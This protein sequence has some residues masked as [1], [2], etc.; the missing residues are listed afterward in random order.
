MKHL[1][2][3]HPW[4]QLGHDIG[5]IPR[6]FPTRSYLMTLFLPKF[7]LTELLC[8]FMSWAVLSSHL[9]LSSIVCHL[10][11]TACFCSLTSDCHHFVVSFLWLHH[12]THLFLLS[13]D[14]I[15]HPFIHLLHR[16]Y[17]FCTSIVLYIRQHIHRRPVGHLHAVIFFPSSRETVDTRLS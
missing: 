12:F 5:R 6:G 14:I 7:V 16:K 11:L 1:C 17:T 8:P 13:F 4:Q 9:L 15:T 2:F 10:N 3:G